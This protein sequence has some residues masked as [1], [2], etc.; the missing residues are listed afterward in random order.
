MRE[1]I[2]F[3][4]SL[5]FVKV[6][7]SRYWFYNSAFSLTIKVIHTLLKIIIIMIILQLI[8]EDV[9]SKFA[10]SHFKRGVRAKNVRVL[11]NIIVEYLQ[12]N[13]F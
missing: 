13:Q 2:Y 3:D 11:T 1:K 9:A 4:M 8:V 7:E 5:L 12:V 6:G 10:I